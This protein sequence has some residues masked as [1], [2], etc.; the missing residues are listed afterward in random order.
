[1]LDLF[2]GMLS[3]VNLV[4]KL[5]ESSAASPNLRRVRNFG[6]PLYHVNSPKRTN[7]LG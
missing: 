4:Q 6:P 7:S 3:V 5:D 2:G 1:M